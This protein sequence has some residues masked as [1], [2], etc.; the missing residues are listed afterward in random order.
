[1]YVNVLSLFLVIFVM[2]S[3]TCPSNV[4]T[5]PFTCHIRRARIFLGGYSRNSL[6]NTP[7]ELKIKKKEL[8]STYPLGHTR[9][10]N[11]LHVE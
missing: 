6:C 10:L 3:T 5:K 8:Y 1:M 11:K 2:L 7:I 4:D 9:A